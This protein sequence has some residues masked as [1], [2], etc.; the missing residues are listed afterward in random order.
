[1]DKNLN[2]PSILSIL[3]RFWGVLPSKR[4]VQFFLLL[5]CMIIGAAAEMISLG[6]VIPFLGSL[7]ETEKFLQ[8]E[9]IKTINNIFNVETSNEFI[10]LMTLLFCVVVIMASI[11]RVLLLK[12]TTSYA[13]ATGTDLSAKVFKLSLYQT[14]EIH[15][16]RNSSEVISAVTRKIS[17]TTQALMHVL[18]ALSVMF[19]FVFFISILLYLDPFTASISLTIL[20][21]FYTCISIIVKKK[22]FRNSEIESREQ[23]KLI[24]IIQEGLSGIREVILENLQKNYA[25]KF[26]NSDRPMRK[27]AGNNIF[28]GGSPR[29]VI[30]AAG[31]VMIACLALY[32]NY[33]ELG[34]KGYLPILG[35]LALGAQRLLPAIQQGYAAWAG[36]MG[37]RQS[38]VDSISFL[39]QKI[40]TQQLTTKNKIS[41]KNTIELRNVEFAYANE[42]Q[43]LFKNLNFKMNCGEKV[44][45][46][47]STGSGKST[48]MDLV[49]GLLY[50][51]KG[52]LL[53]DSIQVDDKYIMSWRNTFA[54]VPQD[55]YLL[56]G[57]FAD[58]IA[59]GNNLTGDINQ[60]A[61]NAC[62][63][64]DIILKDEGMLSMLGERGIKIS[65][66]QKQRIGIARALYKN[67]DFLVLDEATSAL[68]NATEA[69]VMK[70]IMNTCKNM[71]I[72]MIAHRLSSIKNFDKIFVLDKGKIVSV[73]TYD[74]L[75]NNCQ[76]FKRLANQKNL[77]DN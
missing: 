60:A 7:L 11:W 76:I 59:F 3:K 22:L 62:I 4:K 42:E 44:A 19:L 37:S 36:I 49:M 67:V 64:D 50:P 66:G 43:P 47:G 65:G 33:T 17:I 28:I 70:N 74:E 63:Y 8:F 73:G 13:Y 53:V 18:T 2:A 12:L 68:D 29:F 1:L 77:N 39:E 58:N 41:F 46:V 56:D 21:L 26:L 40:A 61:T 31:I 35:A 6:M 5:I 71:T 69:A 10:T 34:I 72:L 51:Q 20:G 52:A 75:L 15:A 55:I 24:K 9:L 45:L 48:L 54:H 57:T 32:F 16:S 30:E 38:L 23:N 25:D 27:A 14:Y